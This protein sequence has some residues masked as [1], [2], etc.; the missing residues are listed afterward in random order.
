MTKT[1]LQ[2]KQNTKNPTKTKATFVQRTTILRSRKQLC[3]SFPLTNFKWDESGSGGMGLMILLC[4]SGKSAYLSLRFQLILA[5]FHLAARDSETISLTCWFTSQS[6]PT[7]GAWPHWIP[8]PNTFLDLPH[9]M[10]HQGPSTQA[11]SWDALVKLVFRNKQ[12]ISSR[13][14]PLQCFD[15]VVWK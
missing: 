13:F 12:A 15:R 2:K 14:L 5:Y 1:K 6:L 8:L 3:L 9:G 11:A 4:S 10:G 7:P